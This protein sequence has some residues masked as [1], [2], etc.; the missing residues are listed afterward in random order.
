MAD[1]SSATPDRVNN[2]AGMAESEGTGMTWPSSLPFELALERARVLDQGAL[3]MLYRRFMPVV[4]RFVLARVSGVQVAEDVTSE[5]FLAVV[6]GI[7]GMRATDE[8]TFAAWVL[9]IARNKV[10]THFRRQ[11]TQPATRPWLPEDD[12]PITVAD[13]GDPLAIITARESWA[14]VV[15][16]L[17]QLTEEQRA[18]VLYRCVLGYATDDVARLLDRQANAIRALQFRGLASLARH[19]NAAAS[20][21]SPG[22]KQHTVRNVRK[23]REEGGNGDAT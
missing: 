17:N 10:A 13:E 11:S 12:Q 2:S 3:T 19:L 21:T 8:L 22:G 4:Y 23:A 9:G 16:A 1:P 15:A 18:V 20:V 7:R 6:T 14:E 5:T